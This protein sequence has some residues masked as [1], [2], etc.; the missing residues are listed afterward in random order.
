MDTTTL[1]I[2]ILVVLLLGG[3]GWS[4]S[5]KR[6]MGPYANGRWTDAAAIVAGAL[7]IALNGVLLLQAF[8]IATPALGAD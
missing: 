1:I 2:V 8:G 3:G 5:V 6:L 7:I 4:T